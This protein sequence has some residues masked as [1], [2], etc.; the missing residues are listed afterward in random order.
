MLLLVLDT[1]P[2]YIQF[3]TFSLL[4]VFLVK[5]LLSIKEKFNM[6]DRVLYPCYGLLV[7]VLGL[8]SYVAMPCNALHGSPG[9]TL[10]SRAGRCPPTIP[11]WQRA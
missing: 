4:I 10:S 2:I 7:T 1:L 6:I 5:C 11:Y 3:V 8:G 9:R